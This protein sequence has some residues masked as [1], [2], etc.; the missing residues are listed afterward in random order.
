MYADM[1]I[2]T[3]KLP[4]FSEINKLGVANTQTC[5]RRQRHHLS[6]FIL[7]TT[8]VPFIICH[9][10][11]DLK[12]AFQEMSHVWRFTDSCYFCRPQLHSTTLTITK[13]N[14]NESQPYIHIGVYINILYIYVCVRVWCA[15]SSY[16][17][18][19]TYVL[20]YTRLLRFVLLCC[21]CRSFKAQASIV[22]GRHKCVGTSDLICRCLGILKLFAAKRVLARANLPWHRIATRAA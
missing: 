18:E 6:I 5:H 2:Y 1:C 8:F 22:P 20:T 10:L 21:L 19:R 12:C 15:G 17:L 4:N 7:S 13:V 3:T 9:M 14:L 11:D 16:M